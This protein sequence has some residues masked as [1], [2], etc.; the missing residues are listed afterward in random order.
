[1]VK[2]ENG[3]EGVPVEHHTGIPLLHYTL[4]LFRWVLAGTRLDRWSDPRNMDLLDA[5][6]LAREW[7]G[8]GLPRIVKTGLSLGPFSS[9]LALIWRLDGA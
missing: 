6:L 9:N 2:P 4:R 5:A 1:M 3:A 8:L 7:P